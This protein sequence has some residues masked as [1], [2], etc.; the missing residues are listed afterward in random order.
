MN[1][2]ELK[3]ESLQIEDNIYEKIEQEKWIN[4]L[5]IIKL[6]MA[7]SFVMIFVFTPIYFLFMSQDVGK[8]MFSGY[9]LLS[10]ICVI[11][12]VYY[13]I[14]Y[15]VL[16]KKPETLHVF[17]IVNIV[18]ESLIVAFIFYV[19]SLIFGGL[20]ILSG[21]VY[22]IFVVMN[23]LSLFRLSFGLEVY[24]SVMCSLFYLIECLYIA[25]RDGGKYPEIYSYDLIF[26][27]G[28]WLNILF[29]IVIGIVC[30]LLAR[31][32]Q[33]LIRQVVIKNYETS[34]IKLVFGKYV[35][36]EIR[37][38]ILET[39]NEDITKDDS[40]VIL[41]C[42]INNFSEILDSY[43]PR[44]IIS[45]LNVFFEK[46]DDIISKNG[47][48]INKFVGSCVMAV[49]GLGKNED[50]K[51]AICE[52]AVKAA[53]EIQRMTNS[54]NSLWNMNNFAIFDIGIGVSQGS[55]ITGNIGSENRKEF[56]CLGDVVNVASRLQSKTRT[57]DS[58]CVLVAADVFQKIENEA[59]K[60]DFKKSQP[61]FLKGK[62]LPVEVYSL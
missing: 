3:L 37:D 54:M 44:N 60:A 25:Y 18:T 51:V 15:K 55:F 12:I 39:K 23:L 20:Q 5:S 31:K 62:S 6:C 47:G 21:P 41:F 40:G 33:K 1:M 16:S 59:I 56:T 27:Y 7:I 50:D 42:D 36:P 2:K 14:S 26:K 61:L 30:G 46:M 28:I 11:S 35:S 52:S 32:A 38:Y 57:E 34:H 9:L 53:K 58:V 43:D 29:F 8:S 48:V 17:R 22:L 13:S 24:S 19:L 4:E 45:Q 10:V 49:F